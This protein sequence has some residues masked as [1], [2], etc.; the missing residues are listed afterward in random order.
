MLGKNIGKSKSKE[1]RSI[2]NIVFGSKTNQRSLDDC[3][4]FE[5]VSKILDKVRYSHSD[6]KQRNANKRK[7][8]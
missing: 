3:P 7:C 1:L 2:W 5:M 4:E 6:G 8:L